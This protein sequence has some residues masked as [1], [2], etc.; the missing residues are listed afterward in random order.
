MFRS[1]PMQLAE[2][3]SLSFLVWEVGLPEGTGRLVRITRDTYTKR[4]V[5]GT[6]RAA[7]M[8][9]FIGEL[10]RVGDIVLGL[11]PSRG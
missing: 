11:C 9:T 2:P 3:P 7:I 4:F 6:Q 10:R 5:P 1:H 8:L